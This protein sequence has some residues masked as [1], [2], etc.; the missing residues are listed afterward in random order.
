MQDWAYVTGM[1]VGSM[2]ILAASWVWIKYQ[3]FGAGGGFLSFVGVVLVG[4]SVWSSA[5]IE[6]SDGSLRAEFERLQQQVDEVA[7]TNRVVERSLDSVAV[8]LGAGRASYLAL[9]RTLRHRNLITA[10][11]LARLE[12]LAPAAVPA[13]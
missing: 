11:D 2:A 6:V 12:T 13:P 3:R 9:A 1:I 10:T 8:E 7:A 4:L 5:R